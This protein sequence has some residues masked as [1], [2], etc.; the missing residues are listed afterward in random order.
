MTPFARIESVVFCPVA[1][2]SPFSKIKNGQSRAKTREQL[3]DG[4]VD[5]AKGGAE[6]L[7]ALLILIGFVIAFS[8]GT[9]WVVF[10]LIV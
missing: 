8:H 1:K 6:C 9:I 5:G 4:N 2:Q 10:K 3:Q 7:V